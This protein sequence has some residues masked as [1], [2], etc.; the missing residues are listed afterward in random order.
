MKP[1]SCTDNWKVAKSLSVNMVWLVCNL[2]PFREGILIGGVMYT[3]TDMAL[4]VHDILASNYLRCGL[5]STEL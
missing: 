4:S 5:M 1:I 2:S 3:T